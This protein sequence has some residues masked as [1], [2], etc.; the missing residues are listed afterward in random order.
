MVRAGGGVRES[1]HACDGV[2]GPFRP[3]HGKRP[4]A[5][6]A[7]GCRVIPPVRPWRVVFYREGCEIARVTVHT[8]S[9]RFARF[10]AL[11]EFPAGYGIGVSLKVSRMR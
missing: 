3:A 4:V 1:Y 11:E 10:L 9:R 8:V 2:R 7:R 6:R 5:R